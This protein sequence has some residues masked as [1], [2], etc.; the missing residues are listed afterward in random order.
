MLAVTTA[1]TV[2]YTVRV[3]ATSAN[4]GPGFD[5]LGIALSL[6][7]EVTATLTDEPTQVHIEGEGAGELLTD[8]GHLV[9]V[10]MRETLSEIGKQKVGNK[11]VG[12]RLGCVNRIPQ[13]RGLGS[14]SAAIVA[15]V[16]LANALSGSPL[17]RQ[18][19]LRIAGRIEG[20]PDNVAPCL[21]GGFTIAW[22]SDGA[23]ARAVSLQPHP[24]VRPVLLVPA[25]RG[26]TDQARAALPATVPFVDA[27]FNAGRSALLVHALTADPQRLFEAT[28][29]RL[30]QDYRAAAMP[31]S[32]EMVRLLRSA[33]VAAVI[34]GAGP[35]V[36][37]LTPLPAG[38][39]PGRRWLT[40][41]LAAETGGAALRASNISDA[42]GHAE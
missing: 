32:A 7:D 8:D 30:H 9:V 38:F 12:I 35:S 25:N 14:S 1:T 39:D 41:S 13:A 42:V 10:A 19:E 23:G 17:S 21:L 31:E 22:S 36:L 15:G 11:T 40:H 2:A 3:P 18:D 27:A 26:L 5:A 33:G 29:D 6:H 20:H 4:L 24:E 16:T 28:E 37:V 34:S